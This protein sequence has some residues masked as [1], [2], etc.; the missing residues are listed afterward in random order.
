MENGNSDIQTSQ[1][2]VKYAIFAKI[3]GVLEAANGMILVLVSFYG[4]I[5]RPEGFQVTAS[6]LMLLTGIL[7]SALGV[8]LF[9]LK[10]W[11]WIISLVIYAGATLF[12]AAD[13]LIEHYMHGTAFSFAFNPVVI[14]TAIMTSCLIMSWKAV[15]VK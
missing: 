13:T 6:I 12:L 4:F 7:Y 2:P 8:F 15:S 9:L 3:V 5:A 14:L 10:R 1:S 11:A